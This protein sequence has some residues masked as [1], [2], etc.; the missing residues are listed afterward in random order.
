[1][2]RAIA[3]IASLPL[4]ALACMPLA[5]PFVGQP[6]LIHVYD[7]PKPPEPGWLRAHSHAPAAPFWNAET[8]V[9]ASH[10]EWV[11]DPAPSEGCK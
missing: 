1:M 10:Y 4:W 5:G 9:R 7:R 3:L 8:V 2:M 11:Y 6:R